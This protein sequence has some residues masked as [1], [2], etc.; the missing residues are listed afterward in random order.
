MPAGP[1]GRAPASVAPASTSSRSLHIAAS[2]TAS[3]AGGSGATVIFPGRIH[4][5]VFGLRSPS[6]STR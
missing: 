5:R 1:L 6:A 3:G 4:S 2:P